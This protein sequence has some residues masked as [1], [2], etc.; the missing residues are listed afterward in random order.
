MTALGDHESG[1]YRAVF[2]SDGEEVRATV[3]RGVWNEDPRLVLTI[4]KREG[5]ALGGFVSLFEGG[6][7]KEDMCAALATLKNLE[8]DLAGEKGPKEIVFD[9]SDDGAP[10]TISE[11]MKDV[12]RTSCEKGWWA[13]PEHFDAE[14]VPSIAAL[15]RLLFAE[16]MMLV[17]TEAGEAVDEYRT[18]PKG[19]PLSAVRYEGDKPVS[20]DSEMADVAI[21]LFD[22]AEAAGIDLEGA[23]RRKRA[24]NRTR[25]YRHGGKVI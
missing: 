17:V 9:E 16:K 22:L 21:R 11:W 24:Y 5:G 13:I 3:V 7:S 2:K 8:E 1:I 19:V 23:M 14:K 10:R 25:P 18:I 4:E 20:L 12:H 6:I 15:A